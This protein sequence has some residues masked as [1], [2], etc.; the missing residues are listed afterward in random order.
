MTESQTNI[1]NINTNYII[2]DLYI[3]IRYMK[4]III[5]DLYIS[6]YNIKIYLVALDNTIRT[7]FFD[8][9]FY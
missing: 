3:I 8:P 7:V 5:D 4:I 6:N 2:D 1:D 9:I